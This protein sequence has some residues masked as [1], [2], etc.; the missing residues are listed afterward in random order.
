MLGVD[1]VLLTLGNHGGQV[2]RRLPLG[3]RTGEGN[4]FDGAGTLGLF[5]QLVAT[6][7]QLADISRV[8]VNVGNGGKEPFN[9]ETANLLV[10]TQLVGIER[11]RLQA[12]QQ[13]IL[14][15]SHIRLFSADT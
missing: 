11:Q 8:K 9:R 6:L 1:P 3:N 10:A 4:P 14:Q 12:V 15:G 13:Q 5:L 2:C 7:N